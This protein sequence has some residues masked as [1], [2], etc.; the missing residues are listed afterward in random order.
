LKNTYIPAILN[1]LLQ[2]ILQRI[3]IT[4]EKAARIKHDVSKQEK[5]RERER[6]RALNIQ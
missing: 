4:N 1:G 6:E 2:D 3:K 5:E